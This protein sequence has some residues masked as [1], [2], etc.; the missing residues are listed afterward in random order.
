MSKHT[1]KTF[2]IYSL[3]LN[4]PKFELEFLK[5]FKTKYAKKNR[6]YRKIP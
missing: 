4:F 3:N 5:L 2:L 1:T 6:W